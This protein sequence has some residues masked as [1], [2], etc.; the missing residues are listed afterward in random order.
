MSNSSLISYTKISPNK[1]VGRNHKIDTITIHCMAGNLSIE[2]CGNLFAKST[3]KASSNYGI[4]SDGRIA[5]YVDEKDRSWATSSSVNDNRAVTI[6]VASESKSPYKVT[7][8][9]YKALIKLVADICKRNGIKKLVWSTNKADRVGHLNGCN[10]TVHRDYANK[11]CVPID[12]EVLTKNGWVKITDIDIG[13]EIACAS[14]DDLKISFEEVYDKVEPYEQDTYTNNE[15]TATKDHRLV[16]CTQKNRDRF[17]ID[18]YSELLKGNRSVYIPLAG[19]SNYDGLPFSEDMEAFLIAVQADG[20]YMYE[21]NTS[22]IEKYYGVEFHLK[23]ERK[24]NR[25]KSI[26]D[27]LHFEYKI[28]NQSDGTTK[29]R[30]Y[31]QDGI[32]IKEDICEKYLQDKHF[33]WEWL[34]MSPQQ[35]KFFL[36]ELLFWDGC[37]AANS[38]CSKVRENLDIVNAIAAMNGVGSRVIGDNVQFR[39]IPFIT[40]VQQT[41]RN[42]KQHHTNKTWVTCVSVKTGIFLMRQYGKTFIIGNCP[43]DYLYNLHGQ[44][45][46]EV[47]ALL[48]KKKETTT[49]T[50][51]FK[52]YKVQ[53][54]ATSLNI[55]KGAGTNYGKNGS[56]KKGEVYTIVEEKKNGSTTW[57]KLKSGAGWIALT[58]YTKKV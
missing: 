19:Y 39:E 47:N 33:T 50:N 57:G 5:L 54:T 36:N 27:N 46:K 53:I 38:Y 56:V 41:K 17:R 49:T 8:K 24:I 14:L 44:I 51:T 3:T 1:T 4:G 16:Y 34:Y 28:N 45:A 37:I 10:M 29:I 26:I 21:K 12:S 31:N 13:D 43:G 9:A 20:H 42:N 35:A 32:N 52:S 23:K 11:A 58:G 25:L 30:I 22:N 6:E 2:T 55:R 18:Y 40:L 48:N 15:L 7:D